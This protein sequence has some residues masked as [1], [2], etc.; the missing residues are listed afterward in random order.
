MRLARGGRGDRGG[1]DGRGRRHDDRPAGAATS[2]VAMFFS[3]AR[4]VC[5]CRR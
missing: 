2:N 4:T 5:N 3:L 1:L